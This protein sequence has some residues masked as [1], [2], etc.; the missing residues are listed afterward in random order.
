MRAVDKMRR[1]A[2]IDEAMQSGVRLAA[3]K[4]LTKPADVVLTIQMVLAQSGFR[5]VSV[6][7]SK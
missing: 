2:R 1:A 3:A 7:E 5:I 6:G 4:G